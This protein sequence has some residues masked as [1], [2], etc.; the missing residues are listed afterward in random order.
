MERSHGGFSP[1]LSEDATKNGL[2]PFLF[3]QIRPLVQLRTVKQFLLFF[4]L[5]ESQKS[6]LQ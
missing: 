2:A 3:S 1:S 4:S 5:E 6:S